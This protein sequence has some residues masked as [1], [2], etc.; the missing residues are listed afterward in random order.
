MTVP[1]QFDSISFSHVE[2]VHECLRPS[3]LTD[4]M[5]LFPRSHQLKE[6]T[7]AGIGPDLRR[8]LEKAKE[9]WLNGPHRSS[10]LS[11]DLGNLFD[12]RNRRDRKQM[13]RILEVFK[14]FDAKQ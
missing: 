6:V 10:L 14:E 7:V 11:F 2:F 9:R 4:P 13:K 8:S 5:Y 12:R 3:E 1:E